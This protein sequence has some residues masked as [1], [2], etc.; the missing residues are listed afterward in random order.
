M[1]R[2]SREKLLTVLVAVLIIAISLWLGE[3][4]WLPGWLSWGLAG[5]M[6]VGAIMKLAGHPAANPDDHAAEA[7]SRSEPDTDPGRDEP[8]ATVNEVREHP[9]PS[10]NQEGTPVP[11][12]A[13]AP[14]EGRSFKSKYFRKYTKYDDRHCAYG[15][16]SDAEVDQLSGP[17]TVIRKWTEIVDVFRMHEEEV[18]FFVCWRETEDAL[19]F[20]TASDGATWLNDTRDPDGYLDDRTVVM[21]GNAARVEKA[22]WAMPELP[23]ALKGSADDIAA[24]VAA[25][26][27]A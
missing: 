24:I 19:I 8:R 17:W 1:E 26:S 23:G 16:V 9:L 22:D 11:A 25:R 14:P 12:E 4:G 15:R 27:T 5:W 3:A 18:N 7:E 21:I 6:A 10:D 2:K 13:E 20:A